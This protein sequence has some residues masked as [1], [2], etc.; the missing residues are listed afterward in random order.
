MRPL[1]VAMLLVGLQLLLLACS[2]LASPCSNS[3]TEQGVCVNEAASGSANATVVSA[4]TTQQ[5]VIVYAHNCCK[6]A[7]DRACRSAMKYKIFNSCDQFGL[8][9]LHSL[10][11]LSPQGQQILTSEK[12]GA[13][14]WLWKP[15]LIWQELLKAA[16][17][18]VLVYMDADCEFVSTPAPLVGLLKEGQD[19]VGFESLETEANGTKAD[20]IALFN[21]T[22]FLDTQQLYAG[23]IILRRSWQSLGFVAQWLAFCQ[24]RRWITDMDNTL[25]P[26]GQNHPGFVWHRNDQA[27]FSLLYKQWGFEV[28]PSPAVGEL[29]N[30]WQLYPLT[31]V[32]HH[33]DASK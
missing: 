30:P 9:D 4:P 14:F 16:E 8:A 6:Q 13:G 28:Y 32:Y 21:A 31:L 7:M 23:L 18:D 33:Y 12:R 26:E 29:P 20:V 25:L 5:R 17:G 22:E 11:A 3:N 10:P 2:S 15:L 19:V 27:I 1:A 24:D